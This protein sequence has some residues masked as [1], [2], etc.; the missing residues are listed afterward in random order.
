MDAI[1]RQDDHYNEVGDEQRNIE[2]VPPVFAAKGTVEQ[3]RSNVVL[4]GVPGGKQQRERVKL[5]RQKLS[6]EVRRWV[7]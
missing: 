2:R 4:E 7:R 6:R 3:M 1:E 5:I